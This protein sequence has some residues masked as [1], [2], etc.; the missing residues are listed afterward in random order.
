MLGKS[1]TEYD[2]HRDEITQNGH[3]EVGI[4]GLLDG[5]MLQLECS[6]L[7]LQL[8]T[9]GVRF[10]VY[11]T[12]IEQQVLKRWIGTQRYIYNQKVEE[13][14]YQLWLK[15]YGKYSNQFE[16]PDKTY[17]EWDQSFSKY[18]NSAPWM[19]EIP[20][21]VRR[22]G[23]A[24]FKDAMSRWGSGKAGKPRYKT[25]NSTQSVLLTAE[26]FSL[27]TVELDGVREVKL[28]LGPKSENYGVL[29][30]VAHCDFEE[31]RQISITQEPDGKWF[32]GFNFKTKE[33]VPA[34]Q[35][36]KTLSEVLGFDRGVVNPVT[37]N[38][39]RFYDFTEQEKIKLERRE[40]GRTKLQAQ[41]ARQKRGSRRRAKTRKRIAASHAKDRRLR[42]AVAH[43]ISNHITV[44]AV[45]R[46]CKA[47]GFEDLRLANMTKR[48]KPKPDPL[49]LDHYLANN[50]AA[51][52]G[53][54]KALLGRNLG[55]IKEFT[56]Y[57]CRRVGLLFVEAEPSC[58]STEC[59]NCHHK[60]K[61]SRVSQADFC[62]VR[63]RHQ[64]HADVLGASNVQVKTFEK[65]TEISPGTSIKNAR[66]STR[67]GQPRKAV[68][69]APP[70]G[71]SI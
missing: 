55:K 32:V 63:C 60:D 9:H 26:C 54:N 3:A 43:R 17:C 42:N 12:R 14:D 33:C 61:R 27:Q 40:K 20:S 22:N 71:A 57:K 8:E 24:R 2:V 59:T 39:G 25:R 46:G 70:M 31:P 15:K 30:W 11:P 4:S 68:L 5:N 52:T 69:I 28:F 51:K 45:E 36:P 29:K 19:S 38:T 23:C 53:L 50:G 41:L 16:E 48:A 18:Q 37:D 62:C 47:V 6:D 10:R 58:T 67:K 66:T 34:P 1:S 44:Q 49:E 64:E 35:I 13:L 65:I 21:F 7:D 56:E